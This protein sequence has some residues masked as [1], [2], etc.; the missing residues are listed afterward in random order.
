VVDIGRTETR[1]EHSF[2]S[3]SYPYYTHLRD[4]SRQ[5]RG[6]AAWSFLQL[7]VSTGSQGTTTFANMVSANYFNVLGI[8]PA[9]GRFF[10]PDEDRT[11]G[12]HPVIVV[13]TRVWWAARSW[14]TA[15]HIP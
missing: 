4:E 5:M 2:G 1:G 10:T 6:V 14:S 7:T 12:A 8:R 11:P 13:E 3:P 9:L 15:C